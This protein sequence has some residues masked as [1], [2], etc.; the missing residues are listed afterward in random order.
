MQAIQIGEIILYAGYEVPKHF[1]PCNGSQFKR[2]DYP[3]LSK[4]IG[5]DY[6]GDTENFGTPNLPN[7]DTHARWLINATSAGAYNANSYN[8]GSI[9]LTL[10]TLSPEGFLP[11][12]GQAVP[13]GPD[14]GSKN[15]CLFCQIGTNFGGDGRET[16][17]V[18]NY[19]HEDPRLGYFIAFNQTMPQNRLD[20]M[21]GRIWTYPYDTRLLNSQG[22]M[23]I[24][25][26]SSRD[27][28]SYG[29]LYLVVEGQYGYN[30]QERTYAIPKVISPL[31]GSFSYIVTDGIRY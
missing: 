17:A 16:F 27:T 28:M 30:P 9:I 15:I 11:C 18:P 19:V 14:N 20:Y 10:K 8:V 31:K 3:E 22:S 24:C 13:I 2:A 23:S 26:G 21:V 12:D 25:D 29:S 4:L 5:N 7:V 6:G 1:I